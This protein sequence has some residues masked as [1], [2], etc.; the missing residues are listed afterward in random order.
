MSGIHPRLWILWRSW[1]HALSTPSQAIGYER[2]ALHI[3]N[4][5][6]GKTFGPV[7]IEKRLLQLMSTGQIGGISNSRLP[8]CRP[9]G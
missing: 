8:L 7:R 9:F 2:S 4:G 6:E 5:C 1:E 3:V